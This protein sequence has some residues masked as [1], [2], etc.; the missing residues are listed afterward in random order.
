MSMI[1]FI[2]YVTFILILLLI[3]V[4][5]LENDVNH[6]KDELSQEEPDES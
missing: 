1:P 2:A 3:K 4:Y 5:K 6:I